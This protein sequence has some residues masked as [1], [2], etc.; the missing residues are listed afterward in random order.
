MKKGMIANALLDASAGFAHQDKFTQQSNSDILGNIDFN[1]HFRN[2]HSS[3]ICFISDEPSDPDKDSGGGEGDPDSSSHQSAVQ[4]KSHEDFM[5]AAR[6]ALN[7]QDDEDTDDK[8]KTSLFDKRQQ[9]QQQEKEKKA[10]QEKLERAVVFDHSFDGFI[11][12]NAQ[13]FPSSVK[14]IR[15]DTEGAGDSI[16]RA[17]LMQA[18]AAKEF[19]SDER[20]LKILDENDQKYVKSSILEKRYEKDIDGQKAWDI[21]GRSV[22]MQNLKSNNDQ[23]R[24]S[25]GAGNDGKY[26]KEKLDAKLQKFYPEGVADVAI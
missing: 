18:T 6:K 14:T 19:F 3:H 9:Q 23:R 11:K 25:T 17:E 12:D 8:E 4:F 13:Y 5:A 21:V 1:E 15:Q 16:Q 22:Y 2:R 26:G 7:T 20:N 24:S 10:N